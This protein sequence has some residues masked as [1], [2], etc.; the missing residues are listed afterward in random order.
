MRLFRK[1]LVTATATLAVLAG[2]AITASPASAAAYNGACGSGY[3]VVN[4]AHVPNNKGTVFLTYN[5]SNDYNCAVTVRNDP[6]TALPMNVALRRA[7][8]ES[9]A[10]YDPGSYTTY[11]GPV[12]VYGN[13]TCMDWGGVI[14]GDQAVR[15][16]TNCS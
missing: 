15:Y 10:K 14:D 2:G 3:G 8:D 16:A 9:S 13:D 12:Y 11:S 6:G 5:Y 7:G 1:S 4:S